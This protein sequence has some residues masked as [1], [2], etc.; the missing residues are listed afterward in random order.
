[1]EGDDASFLQRLIRNEL[2]AIRLDHWGFF[3]PAHVAV[4]RFLHD[5]HP[6]AFDDV[7]AGYDTEPW[8]SGR[9][10]GWFMQD[11]LNRDE[12]VDL[13]EEIMYAAAEQA[14]AT[15][16]KERGFVRENEIAEVDLG[17]AGRLARVVLAAADEALR[18]NRIV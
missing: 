6:S 4:W 12:Y 11:L 13:V 18:A 7:K 9:G 16:A 17:D 3:F 5:R 8:F 2:L 10:A 15:P 14:L 1:M